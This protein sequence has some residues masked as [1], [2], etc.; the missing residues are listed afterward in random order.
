M[1][2]RFEK[3]PSPGSGTLASGALAW[4]EVTWQQCDGLL[5]FAKWVYFAVASVVL[6]VEMCQ[7]PFFS[8]SS[9]IEGDP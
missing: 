1:Q 7:Y 6:L 4:L 3:W 5:K 8:F 2:A 9:T